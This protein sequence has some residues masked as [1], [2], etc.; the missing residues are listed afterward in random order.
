LRA[1]P[2]PEGSIPR[3]GN[4]TRGS[5]CGSPGN[6][7]PRERIHRV[8][9]TLELRAVCGRCRLSGR[10]RERSQKRHEGMGSSC[11]RVACGLVVRRV[12]LPV[13]ETLCR[14]K[15]H[16]RHRH[17]TRPEGLRVE[18]RVKRLRKP[19]GAA[20]PGLVASVLVAPRCLI[21]WR[22]AR[23]HGR[24]VDERRARAPSGVR[25]RREADSAT[26]RGKPLK[27]ES[28]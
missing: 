5:A 4:A 11:G 6:T 18:Q 7:G 23:P 2:R 21:R 12:R 19:E 24:A 10:L 25:V 3:R 26:G 27:V 13:G 1:G 14:R 28:P 9:K 22:V 20:Q 15:A 16:E 8:P 17:E